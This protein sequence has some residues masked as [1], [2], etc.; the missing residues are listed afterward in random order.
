MRRATSVATKN[1]PLRFTSTT[2]SQSCSVCSSSGF[3]DRSAR[4]VDEH[5]DAAELVLDRG[6]R[7]RNRRDVCDVELRDRGN[8][9]GAADLLRAAASSASRRR[10]ASPTFA[11]SRAS[12]L[13]K[14]RPKPLDA[15]VIS[16]TLPATEKAWVEGMRQSI[17]RPRDN[18]A[19]QPRR[20]HQI[21]VARDDPATVGLA[22][23]NR[24]RVAGALHRLAALRRH[25]Q[26]DVIA[27]V[28]PVAQHL[29]LHRLRHALSLT[30]FRPAD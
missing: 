17:D 12:T 22:I 29:D 26:V 23:E 9:A 2:A 6:D 8:A 4:I 15:P 3:D 10:A 5:V 16:A 14:C 18:R 1:A 11:P 25:R 13:A 27:Q 30:S 24:Q 19:D 28:G 21:R 7:R 20:R